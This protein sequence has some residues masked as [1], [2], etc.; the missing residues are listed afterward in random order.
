M[1]PFWIFSARIEYSRKSNNFFGTK[2]DQSLN[3]KNTFSLNFQN[4]EL[5]KFVIFHDLL[6]P[7]GV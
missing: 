7:Q 6:T 1:I 5:E 4:S 2:Y 3:N